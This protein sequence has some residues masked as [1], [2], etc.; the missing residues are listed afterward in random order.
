MRI[1]P[2][3]DKG[4]FVGYWAVLFTMTFAGTS[5]H[6]IFLTNAIRGIDYQ[7]IEAAQN[8]GAKNSTIVMK[9]F[10]PMLKP[11][12]YA[13]T[14]LIFLSGLSALAVPL[15]VGG[16][17][18]QTINPMVIQLAKSSYS[19]DIAMLLSVILGF[20]TIILLTYMNILERRGNYISISK[21]KTRLK[22]QKIHNKFLNIVTHILSYLIFIVYITPMIIVILFSFAPTTDI[23]SGILNIN[24][25]SFVHYKRLFVD[26]TSF[27]P[28][29][30]SIMYSSI[31]TIGVILFA[32]SISRIT[33]R[34]KTLVSKFYE[35]GSLIP[36][37]L[38]STLIALGFLTT[39]NKPRLLAFNVVLMTTPFLMIIAYMVV[40]IP[41]AYR[42]IR[43][44]FFSVDSELEEA[45][46][47]MGASSFYTFIKVILPI[48]LPAA[49]AVG[50]LI[51][52]SLLTDYNLSVFLYHPL[53]E[54]LGISI[55]KNTTSEVDLDAK[56]M[57][58]VYSVTMM[59]I[60][61]I[62]IYYVYGR[63]TKDSKNKPFN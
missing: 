62:V 58:Y 47:S 6:I 38:P 49:L 57:V 12:L 41:F 16:V 19:R 4:W 24:S 35:Y 9:V 3:L 33:H 2:N 23:V 1:I 44:A 17:D 15:M 43:A 18:F 8:M 13:L 11:T 60:S 63:N 45:A 61:S 25:L 51:F 42:M 50:A 10:L 22:K 37:L 31:A 34:N 59:I 54:P 30:V 27:K 28:Y 56:A 40:K 29:L 20:S 36:W 7:V 46:K 14:I 32:L 48:L 55:Y 5:N 53:L 52:N 26:V 21:S 39:Y